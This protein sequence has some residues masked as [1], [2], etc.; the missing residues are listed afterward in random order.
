MK[1]PIP[2]RVTPPGDFA[3]NES[4]DLDKADAVDEL[5]RH[6]FSGQWITLPSLGDLKPNDVFHRQLDRST[7]A[8]IDL[9]VQN[10]HVLFRR[11]F[12]RP[13]AE[14]VRVFITADDYYKLYVNGRFVTQGPAAGYAF[15]YFYNVVDLPPL[16]RP[17]SRWR[18]R[19]VPRAADRSAKLAPH[20]GRRGDAHLRRVGQGHQVEH[21]ALP[22]HADVRGRLP[23]RLGC[24]GGDGVF[25]ALTCEGGRIQMLCAKKVGFLVRDSGFPR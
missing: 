10:R 14:A 25:K 7:V 11:T 24:Q 17:A 5:N 1:Q 21:G 12:D 13:C 3:E 2:T 19:V 18:G 23:L 20:A 15:H 4:L 22:P 8:D 6:R 9:S 16:L